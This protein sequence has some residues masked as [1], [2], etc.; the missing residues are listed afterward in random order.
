MRPELVTAMY[1][2]TITAKQT[3]TYSAGE[4]LW[5]DR[6]LM[7]LISMAAVLAG[8]LILSCG[9]GISGAM[10]GV[11]SKRRE[12]IG[13]LRALG[14][15]RRQIRRMFGRE[16]LILA[17]L[18]SPIAILAGCAAVWILSLMIPNW[19]HFGLKLW[20][21]LPIILFSVITILLSGYLP[22]VQ[23][24]KLMPMSVIRDSS[25]FSA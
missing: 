25:V 23:A 1:G 24:S 13:V 21:I 15:T 12:E 19:V 2:L 3:V 22:L 9:I 16:N 6:E 14:A 20:L 7:D 18:V 5:A 8:A 11:L 17:L 10:D 4:M